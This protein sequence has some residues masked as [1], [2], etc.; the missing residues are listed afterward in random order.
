MKSARYIG[1]KQF[2]RPNSFEKVVMILTGDT[3]TVKRAVLEYGVNGNKNSN[4]EEWNVL[5]QWLDPAGKKNHQ[6]KPPNL[7]VKTMIEKLLLGSNDYQL[8]SNIQDYYCWQCRV[9]FYNEYKRIET[10]NELKR[11]ER[12]VLFPLKYIPI[13]EGN[14][15]VE[16]EVRLFGNYLLKTNKKVMS[17]AVERLRNR[18]L[19]DDFELATEIVDYFDYC[20]TDSTSIVLDIILDKIEQF[21]QLH[22]TRK[23][24]KRYLIME[25]FNQFISQ[26]WDQL[27]SLLFCQEDNHT[28]TNTLYK[29]FEKQFISIRTN[30]I[31]DICISNPASV[32]PTLLELRKEI[33]TVNDFNCVVVELLSKFNLKVINPS[34]VTADALFL[35]IRTIK[36]FSILDPSGRYLQTIS[37]YVKPHFRQRKDLVHLLLF[38][39]L[40]LD[41]TDQLN[42]MPSQVS[43][44]KLTAL[45]NEL[46]DTEICSYTEE[47]DDVV[48]PMIG[49]FSKEEDSMVLEQVIKRYMEWIPEVP[50][51]F[52][53]GILSDHKLDLFDILLELLESKETLVIEFKNLLTKKLLDLRGYTL[54][55]KWSKFLS[56]LKKRFDNR[57]TETM[58]EE[59]LNNI[60]T[61]DI[62]LRDIYKSRQIATDMQ[63]DLHNTNVKVYPKIVSALYWSNNSDTQSKAGDF[64]MDG[65]LEHLLELYSRFYS[66]KQIGQKLEL[67][68]DNG[69]VSLNLSFLDGRTVHCKASLRQYSVLTLFKSP[70]HDSNFPT[71]GLTISE[72]CARSGMQSKQMADILRYWVSKDVLYFSDGKYRT[73]EFLRWKGDSTYAAIPD[74]LEESVV[75][76]SSQH[77]DKQE[78]HVERA[79]P[80]IKDILLNLGTL[81]IDK[82]HALLQSAMPK[83]SHYSTVNQKQLQDYL[84]TL[85]EEGVLSSASN[86]SYKLPQIR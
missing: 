28:I 61:I 34:I 79:L 5:L 50:T 18:M 48:D 4:A 11:I 80:Y 2:V 30:E 45:T 58:D 9:Y 66:Q 27:S 3:K 60:N 44:E 10:L 29:Y 24:N 59:D 17:R 7:L 31:F 62:M 78:N 23:W 36:T 39:M 57:S 86:D 53:K 71:E 33:S 8:L 42:T 6:L 46:K 63:L 26:Y 22:Y 76:R 37:S 49:S 35:Y 84:D 55:K 38:S 51:S 40:G 64:E 12:H 14:N 68:R 21:C 65:E 56:L 20:Q 54:D 74:V 73:L 43:E 83:D 52:G 47:S 19:E 69:S 70:K 15:R 16:N 32:Q 75:E 81:K 77:E 41:E 1:D 13:F 67:R 82:L 72:L 85:V 25:T